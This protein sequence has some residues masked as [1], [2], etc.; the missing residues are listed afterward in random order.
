LEIFK[1]S[2]KGHFVKPVSARRSNWPLM[3][4]LKG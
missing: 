1:V 2:S 3:S 4:S